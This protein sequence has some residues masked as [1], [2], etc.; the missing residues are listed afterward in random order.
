MMNSG[1]DFACLTVRLGALQE[2]Y[3]TCRQ[4]S[5]PAV[6]AGVVKADAYGTGMPAAA[7]ALR[8]AG[9]DTYFVARLSEG[10]GLRPLVPDARIFV[11]DGAQRDTVPALLSSQLIPVLNSLAQ[12]DVWSAAARARNTVLEAA[13]HLDTGMNRLG[14]PTYETAEL[15]ASASSLLEGINLSLIMSHL[16]FAE[17]PAASMNAIQLERFRAALAGLPPAPASLS[18]SGGILLGRDFAFDLVRPGVALFG[19]NPQLKKPNLFKPVAILSARILQ[20][21]RVDK[22]EGVGY[23]ATFRAGRPSTL[24]TVALGYADGLMRAIGN[25]GMAA[26]A[27]IRVPVVGRVSMDLVTLDVTDVPESARAVGAEVEFLGDTISLEEFAAAAN[28][29]S[30]EILTSLGAR[31][32]RRYIEAS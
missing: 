32:P 6:V 31:A 5:G 22:G 20:L 16:A 9:C 21:R 26:I 2:N 14:L 28:T 18:S 25:R 10:L 1:Q 12:I 11:L 8:E 23:G 24:A 19:G 30:Y 7:H 17:D 27:G 4:L 15:I 3:R 13:I 29:A